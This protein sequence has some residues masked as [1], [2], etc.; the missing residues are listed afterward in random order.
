MMAAATRF[1][2]ALPRV[3]LTRLPLGRG[4]ASLSIPAGL[5]NAPAP[6]VMR[7]FHQTPA[8]RSDRGTSKNLLPEF[9]LKDKVVVVSGGARGLGLVQAEALL[10]A[11][12][13]GRSSF[14]LRFL[15]LTE[16]AMLRKDAQSPPS[17]A[18]PNPL[19]TFLA[20]PNGR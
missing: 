11:G 6:S 8:R 16:R 1:S 2:R 15:C 19:R 12:A 18:F 7:C 9:S 3:G 17:T 4:S 5:H 14:P 10:D 20:C 13:T